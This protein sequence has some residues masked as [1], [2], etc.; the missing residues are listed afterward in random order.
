[1]PVRSV[2]V[3]GAEGDIGVVGEEGVDLVG[4]EE[5]GE[6]VGL[7]GKGVGVNGEPEAAGQCKWGLARGWAEG[8]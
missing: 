4:V 6:G 5:A 1:M 7:V 2:G 3:A 8:C